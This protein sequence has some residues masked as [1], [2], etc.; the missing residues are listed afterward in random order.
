MIYLILLSEA[1]GTRSNEHAEQLQRGPG[2]TN[3]QPICSHWLQRDIQNYPHR[4]HHTVWSWMKLSTPTLTRMHALGT[5]HT[6]MHMYMLNDNCKGKLRGAWD[7]CPKQ[8]TAP[9]T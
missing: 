9:Q 1:A 3:E 6:C 4:C 8:G 5:L 2:G 7:T